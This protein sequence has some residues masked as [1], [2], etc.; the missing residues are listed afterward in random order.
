MTIYAT[1][2]YTRRQER[3]FNTPTLTY[4]IDLTYGEGG[5][6]AHQDITRNNTW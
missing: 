1:K 2:V 5:D 6:A 3:T 4:L